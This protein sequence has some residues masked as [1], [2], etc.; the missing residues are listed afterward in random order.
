MTN[1]SENEKICVQVKIK[2]ILIIFEKVIELL[3]EKDDKEAQKSFAMK[4]D[5]ILDFHSRDTFVLYIGV[6]LYL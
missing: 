6:D 5:R 2:L 4:Y 3:R 1:L